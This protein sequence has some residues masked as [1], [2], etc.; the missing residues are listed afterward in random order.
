MKE[1]K[2]IDRIFQEKFKDFEKEPSEKVWSS[3][4]SKLDE[5]EEKKPFILPFWA[6]IGGVAAVLALIMASL[7]FN[8]DPFS[9]NNNENPI[10]IE[11]P[12]SP[13]P[14]IES[15]KSSISNTTNS[16]EVANHN[17]EE[18]SHEKPG[19][20]NE[21]ATITVAQTNSTSANE[22]RGKYIQK[23]PEPVAHRYKN[24]IKTV[25]RI[26]SAGIYSQDQMETSSNS[27]LANSVPL[28]SLNMPHNQTESSQNA[29]ALLEQREEK[30]ENKDQNISSKKLQLST[31]AAPVFYA[32]TGSGNELSNQFANNKSTSE[33]TFSYG[34]KIAYQVG[35]KL[36][37]RTGISK[38]NMSNRIQD[39]NYYPTAT[40]QGF[41]NL[42]RVED[43]LEIRTGLPN[44]VNSNPAIANN[45][46]TGVYSP[47]EINQQF[48]FIEVPVELEYSVLDNR[49][50][51]NLIGGVSSLFLDQNR[52]DLVAGNSITVL[53]TANNINNTSFST[54]IGLGLDYK[55]NNSFGISVEPILKY[56]FNTFTNV[57]NVR[58]L[59]FGIYSGLNFKF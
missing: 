8:N 21:S 31:F 45:L 26:S 55:L 59:N 41:D 30:E 43:N 17:S 57:D 47:G 15:D 29:L 51:M 56:Q 46:V 19:F 20:K 50:G 37:V 18:E 58:P 36:K 13:K 32:N 38:V 11:E 1:K 44:E 27:G 9:N 2:N 22:N 53:G 14:N 25:N 39:I 24:E 4:A 16:S 6:K 40:S 42:S 33:I 52:V 54:N 34:M 5:K 28:D 12:E 48:G 23:K 3:I 49:F 35:S 10:V 7:F